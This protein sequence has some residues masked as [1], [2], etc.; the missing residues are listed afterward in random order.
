MLENFDF[1][2]LDSPEFK[3]DSVREELVTPLLHSLG[4]RAHGDFQIIRSKALL[5]PFVMI[6]S[7]QHKVNIV[8]DYLLRAKNHFAWVLD[9]KHPNQNI[10]SGTNVEQVY[11]YAIHPEVR[12]KLYALC[13]GRELTVFHIN[14]TQPVMHLELKD[15]V[16]RREELENLLSPYTVFNYK[17]QP[18]NLYPDYGLHLFKLGYTSQEMIH[19]FYEFPIDHIIRLDGENFSCVNNLV[20]DSC[21]FAISVDFN[22]KKLSSLVNLAPKKQQSL[23]LDG[24]HKYPFKVDVLPPL[25]VNIEAKLGSLTQTKSE[26]IIPLIVTNFC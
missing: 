10:V 3:E 22:F 16:K 2:L 13:N 9:A 19:F 8:P 23:I 1:K 4:Y 25:A 20:V 12:V 6:G 7:K 14:Q 18:K 11:S 24:L 21:E 17:P 26:E 15:L 5:H